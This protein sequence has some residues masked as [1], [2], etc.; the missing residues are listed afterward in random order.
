MKSV[1]F[2]GIIR[3]AM[4]MKNLSKVNDNVQTCLPSCRIE[5]HQFLDFLTL[6]TE[7]HAV[8]KEPYSIYKAV[9]KSNGSINKIN[10]IA[11]LRIIIKPKACVGVGP[12]CTSQQICYHVLGLVHGIW[13]PIPRSLRCEVYNLGTG[14]GTSVLEIVRACEKASGKVGH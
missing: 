6:K 10:Q 2:T 12:L 3:P 13:T 8:C 1:H 7:V 14:K 9:L 5:T 11:Q 4:D